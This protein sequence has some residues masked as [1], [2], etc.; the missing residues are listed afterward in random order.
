MFSALFGTKK[1]RKNYAPWDEL[2]CAGVTI[3]IWRNSA[4][5]GMSRF[6]FGISRIYEKQ[7]ET[8]YAKTYEIQNI[9]DIFYGI[10]KLANK[11][12]EREDVPLKDRQYLS[13]IISVLD[14][15]LSSPEVKS[16]QV[17]NGHGEPRE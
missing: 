8:H 14:R 13:R 2:R 3:P 16:D 4:R 7:G 15:V 5:D 11:L 6:V 1:E 9:K 17:V 10:E 12:I